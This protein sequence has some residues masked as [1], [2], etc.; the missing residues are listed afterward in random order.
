MSVSEGMSRM[1]KVISAVG[2]LGAACI[3]LIIIIGTGTPSPAS[4]FLVLILA[5]VIWTPFQVIAWIIDG[6]AGN[7]DNNSNI[8]W[9]ST[10]QNY[11]RSKRS[12][13]QLLD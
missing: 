5:V 10:I 12:T 4:R 11:V 13:W 6:F 2:W 3:S 1:A 9:P 8:I 7:T